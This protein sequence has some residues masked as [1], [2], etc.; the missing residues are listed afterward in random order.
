MDATLA[1]PV[2]FHRRL[3]V[4][5]ATECSS[6]AVVNQR[7]LIRCSVPVRFH[8]HH[9]VS[10][11][12]AACAFLHSETFAFM[13]KSL[14]TQGSRGKRLPRL[15]VGVAAGLESIASLRAL[16]GGLNDSLGLSI[17]VVTS[18]QAADEVI[19]ALRNETRC[20]LP[21]IEVDGP[22]RLVRDHIYVH[23]TENALAIEGNS[24]QLQPVQSGVTSAPFDYFFTS[25]ADQQHDRAVGIL[26]ANNSTDGMLGLKTISDAGGM[27]ILELVTNGPNS[28]LSAPRINSSG[29]DHTLTIDDILVE[30]ARYAQHQNEMCENQ[31][32][33]QL[34]KQIIEAIPA[35]AEAVQ[36]HTEHNFRHYK[37]TT[38]A[39]RIRRRMQVLK[40]NSVSTYVDVVSASRDE[41]MRLF[42]DLLI[43]VT[44]F[45][46]DADAFESLQTVVLPKL[47][48]SR[49]D[50]EVIRV[51]VPGCATGE[52]A[53]SM[54]IL[55]H[56]AIEKAGTAHRFQIF[57]TDLDERALHTA[58]QGTYPTGI[59]EEVS[60]ER[61]KKYFQKR[62]MRYSVSK[63]IRDNVIFSSHNLIVD[64]PFTRLD[65]ISCRN[66]LIYLGSHLQKKLI[67]LFHYALRP[68]GYLFLGPSESMSSHKELFRMVSAKHRITQ[69]RSTAIA[70]PSPQG[71]CE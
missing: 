60:P 11:R 51:W 53:Y 28:Q 20:T 22:T 68:G 10:T 30:L 9:S 31:V 12:D 55:F 63:S 48:S 18:H 71:H 35:I 37:V 64:P 40:N 34:N 17:V 67:P 41:A 52:E 43:S 15:V 2:L 3:V 24:L 8:V 6:S 4:C 59:S 1:L 65:L 45:F 16:V 13:A 54:A 70:S 19:Q 36:R 25:L 29:I 39:R 27:T 56:E 44:A 21:V 62:G 32:E 61:L 5:E 69:R 50:S 46:R 14:S 33:S 49:D 38:L 42:R 23:R 26:L 57:A 47:L 7:H 58:R 66:L